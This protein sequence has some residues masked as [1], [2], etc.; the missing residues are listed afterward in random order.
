[1]SRGLHIFFLGACVLASSPP[2]IQ[3]SV[4]QSLI[5]IK[6]ATY[7]VKGLFPMP[8]SQPEWWAEGEE[9]VLIGYVNCAVGQIEFPRA[10]WGQENGIGGRLKPPL[11]V[12]CGPSLIQALGT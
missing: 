2:G 1:M 4:M 10:I 9:C 8:L 11:L 6:T 5:L 3:F 7:K 12:Y